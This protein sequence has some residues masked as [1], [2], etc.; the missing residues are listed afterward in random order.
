M[1]RQNGARN[2][3][4]TENTSWEENSNRFFVRSGHK[5]KDGIPPF[6]YLTK[7]ISMK[8]NCY[9]VVLLSDAKVRQYAV[10]RSK[11]TLIKVNSALFCC[12]LIH[13]KKDANT[14]FLELISTSMKKIVITCS[15]VTKVGL[16]LVNWIKTKL[17]KLKSEN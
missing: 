2:K 17:T 11:A 3:A 1:I 8:K 6:S 12:P 14:S 7:P 16:R 5:K 13:K 10:N 15:D 4:N 9:Y